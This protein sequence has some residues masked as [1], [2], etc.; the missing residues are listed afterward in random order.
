MPRSSSFGLHSKISNLRRKAVLRSSSVF[1]LIGSLTVVF[2]RGFGGRF[3]PGGTMAGRLKPLDLERQTRLGKYA[4]GDGLYLIVTGPTSKSWSSRY[5][6][7]GKE[8]WHGLGP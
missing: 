2:A 4:D 8:R 7:D 1:F 5:W 3:F 6:K